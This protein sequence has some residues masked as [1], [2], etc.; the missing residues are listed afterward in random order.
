MNLLVAQDASGFSSENLPLAA[1]AMFF[2]RKAFTRTPSP[3]F[4]EA[5][6]ASSSRWAAVSS[7][8]IVKVPAVPG[9]VWTST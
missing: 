2:R 6:A 8:S 9:V 1:G 4:R 3:Q 7:A 5:S